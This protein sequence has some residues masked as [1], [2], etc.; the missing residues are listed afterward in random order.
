MNPDIKPDDVVRYL[1]DHPE[2]FD[3]YADLL[4]TR[5]RGDFK[6]MPMTLITKALAINPQLSLI[7]I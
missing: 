5:A 6:G 7:H 1:H 3:Q 2:F 4:A